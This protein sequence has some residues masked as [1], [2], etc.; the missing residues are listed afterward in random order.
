MTIGRLYS[1]NPDIDKCYVSLHFKSNQLEPVLLEDVKGDGPWEWSQIALGDGYSA[2]VTPNGELYTWGQGGYGSLGH[3]ND[4]DILKPKLVCVDF[5][6]IC[7]GLWKQ[8]V[9]RNR[10]WYWTR[11][12]T[13]SEDTEEGARRGSYS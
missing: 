2:A 5:G 8:R 13:H 3:E 1:E 11:S 9:W 6:W 10:S 12:W 4:D 7:L